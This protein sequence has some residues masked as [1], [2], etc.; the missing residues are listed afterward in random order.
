MAIVGS[1]IGSGLLTTTG[2]SSIDSTLINFDDS[3]AGMDQL[4]GQ[5]QQG[6]ALQGQHLE[7][8]HQQKNEAELLDRAKEREEKARKHKRYGGVEGEM[9]RTELPEMTELRKSVDEFRLK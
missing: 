2:S 1:G 9:F 5:L 8:F 7:H 6:Q 4:Q 3:T